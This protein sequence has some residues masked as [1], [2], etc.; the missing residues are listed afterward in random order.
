MM[1][2]LKFMFTFSDVAKVNY[3]CDRLMFREN[4]SS[5]ASFFDG[6][7]TIEEGGL[8]ASSSYSSDII[9]YENEKDLDRLKDR[10]FFLKQRQ[11]APLSRL[12]PIR[13]TLGNCRNSHL[14][15]PGAKA[16]PLLSAASGTVRASLPTG[17][18]S[19]SLFLLILSSDIH[20]EV[21]GHNRLLD[22]MGNDMD[23]SRGI[24]SGTVDRFKMLF[25]KKSGCA[26]CKIVGFLVVFFLVFYYLIRS[27]IFFRV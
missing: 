2:K 6:Y 1:L 17:N 27:I 16:E 18:C 26:M 22:R 13:E 9:E 24:L 5:R 23:A 15:P 20:D 8:K 21:L 19:R 12:S 3:W 4:R 14:C 7:D 25:E 11:S 10:V